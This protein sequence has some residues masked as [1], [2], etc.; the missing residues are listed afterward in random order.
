MLA[1]QFVG[2]R[3]QFRILRSSREEHFLLGFEV[4]SDFLVKNLPNFGLPS[5]DVHVAGLC[6]AF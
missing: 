2:Q 5:S 1:Q 4:N 6:R 3:A